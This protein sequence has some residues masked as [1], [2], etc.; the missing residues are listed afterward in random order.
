MSKLFMTFASGSVAE[1]LRQQ[2]GVLVANGN[3]TILLSEGEKS[4]FQSGKTFQIE[5]A[6]GQFASKGNIVYANIPVDSN[7]RSL[8]FH[9]LLKEKSRLGSSHSGFAAYRLGVDP[10]D[11]HGIIFI[12]FTEGGNRFRDSTDYVLFQEWLK[13]AVEQKGAGP[14]IKHYVVDEAD[15]L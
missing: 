15:D 14:I 9:R 2:P 13:E 10:E 11:N 4:P 12:Q 6:E 7:A 5:E 8:L 3:E 1:R